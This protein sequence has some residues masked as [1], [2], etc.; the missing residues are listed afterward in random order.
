MTRLKALIGL[1]M[2]CDIGS[3]RL[4]KLLDI[5]GEPENILKASADKLAAAFGI[6]GNIAAKIASLKEVDIDAELKLAQKY[7]LNI[8]A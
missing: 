2:F 8:I 4:K 5:F 1:N 3:T 7:N 6:G